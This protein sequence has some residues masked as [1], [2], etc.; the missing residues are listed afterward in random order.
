MVYLRC[1][2]TSDERATITKIPDQT[3][4]RGELIGQDTSFAGA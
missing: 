4:F 2:L 1:W 3:T